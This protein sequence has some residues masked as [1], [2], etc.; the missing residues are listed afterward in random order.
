MTTLVTFSTLFALSACTG[1]L[2]DA[3]DRPGSGTQGSHDPTAPDCGD[4]A[5]VQVYTDADGDGYGDPASGREACAAE[6]GEVLHAGDCN[7]GEALAW[8]AAF[9]EPCDGVDNDCDGALPQCAR[10]MTEGGGYLEGFSP[11]RKIGGTVAFAGDMTGDGRPDVLLTGDWT[12][13]GMGGATYLVSGSDL[14]GASGSIE[15]VVVASWSDETPHDGPDLSWWTPGGV[16]IPTGDLTGDSIDD[17]WIGY[18]LEL[19]PGGMTGDLDRSVSRGTIEVGINGPKVTSG[20]AN[21]LNGDGVPDVTL[22]DLDKYAWAFHGPLVDTVHVED[23]AAVSMR[24]PDD[25]SFRD[26]TTVQDIDGDGSME[27]IVGTDCQESYSDGGLLPYVGVLPGTVNG[28]IRLNEDEEMAG[29]DRFLTW[30]DCEHEHT[31]WGRGA[32]FI[33][34]FTGDGIGDLVV[35][36]ERTRTYVV[37]GPFEGAIDPVAE[38]VLVIEHDTPGEWMPDG[39]GDLDGDGLVEIYA[40]DHGPI[41]GAESGDWR[42]DGAIYIV[43]GGRTGVITTADADAAFFG[44]PSD[45]HNGMT[46][47][48]GGDLDEDGL[49][50]ILVGM[51]QDYE[52]FA[53]HAGRVYFLAG[54]NLLEPRP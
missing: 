42:R 24:L 22:H 7:D 35:T 16:L 11:D 26:S 21:D 37:P 13:P 12:A 1:A 10:L 6:A 52:P 9:D 53:G 31:S 23:D 17:A 48:T 19:I 39:L 29:R 20:S 5:P 18:P 8:T 4:D 51:P 28:D 41:P 36:S 15:S 50:D 14:V 34:D 49:Q 43:R 54:K 38:A 44:Q 40:V 32:S 2:D 46:V 27:L 45:D 30:I 47:I 25:F 33:G 3:G